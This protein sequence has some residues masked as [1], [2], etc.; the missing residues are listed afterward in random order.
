MKNFKKIICMI[1]CAVMTAAIVG[2]CAVFEK[3]V[4]YYNN[5]VVATVGTDI[6]I[7]KGQLS[8]AYG[9][10]GYQYVSQYGLTVKEAYD[11]T[12][13]DLI[14]RE[15]FVELAIQEFS[16]HLSAKNIDD[17][18]GKKGADS[19][20][21]IALFE[22]EKAEVRKQAFD[23][24]DSYY[25]QLQDKVRE[26]KNL[27][28]NTA[29]GAENPNSSAKP[30]AAMDPF[31]PFEPLVIRNE[32]GFDNEGKPVAA[33]TIF[34]LNTAGYEGKELL[35]MPQTW[36][37]DIDKNGDG[38]TRTV[39]SNAIALLVRLLEHNERGMKVDAAAAALVE[40]SDYLDESQRAV[41]GRELGRMIEDYSK[42]TLIRRFQDIFDLGILT[43]I[44]RS[45][46]ENDTDY[47]EAIRSAVRDSGHATKA[48]LL[49]DQ[50]RDYYREQGLRQYNRFT[51]DMDT[52]ESL[53]D[54]VIEGLDGIYWL[55]KDVA[56]KNFTVSHILVQYTDAQKATL[57][58]LKADYRSGKI[59]EA[60]YNSG[61]QHEK[62]NLATYAR[63]T[64]GV[65]TG[66]LVYATQILDELQRVIAGTADERI[67]TF[68][69]YIY[70]YNADPGMMNAEFEYVLGVK[71]VDGA[72]V[73]N[74]KMV[75]EFTNASLELFGYE[76]NAS[77]GNWEG[78]GNG[79]R[80]G[81]SDLVYT[82]FG[83]HI[84]MYTRRLSDFVY[85]TSVNKNS[86]DYNAFRSS[87]E[88]KIDS[89]LFAPLN[90]YGI[91]YDGKATAA[92][93]TFDTIIEKISRPEY[94][95]WRMK[96][97]AAFKSERENND[98]KG[99]LLHPI[100]VFKDKYKDLIKK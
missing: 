36:S 84:I 25:K 74:S 100:N 94:D 10:F 30:A 28:I 29:E 21:Y 73:P 54:K 50:A 20:F 55:P 75:E 4:D 39:K 7:T 44:D 3:D 46:Y 83:V 6:K 19:L 65:E 14:D 51:K 41:I 48:S 2:G 12:L 59:D 88:A 91:A 47:I 26:E 87:F 68:R 93:T 45:K 17:A 42:A 76:K 82:D 60:K 33:N 96:R 98:E 38:I 9:G 79:D 16:T 80:G 18:R 1:L 99:K 31:T 13:D 56:D 72:L 5:M 57:D 64:D 24:L 70:K 90:S 34:E 78:Q 22:N 32:N 37:A 66:D 8:A 77:T 61:I 15:I 85:S 62:D 71:T 40:P 53:S 81:M 86:I 11:R 89:F 35:S 67:N 69:D 43:P 97:I 23:A 58:K 92:K 52:V 49:A 95:I 63:D 27:K